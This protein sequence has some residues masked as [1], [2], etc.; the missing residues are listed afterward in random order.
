MQIITITNKIKIIATIRRAIYT[1]FLQLSTCIISTFTNG[2]SGVHVIFGI[3]D[4]QIY[5]WNLIHLYA[6][7]LISTFI[8][9]VFGIHV[10]NGIHKFASS[11]ATTILCYVRHGAN[12]MQQDS[13]LQYNIYLYWN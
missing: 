4:F 3:F 2:I 13:N 5:Q 10:I 9:G 6:V 1:K 8:Y 11:T 12:E 7:S